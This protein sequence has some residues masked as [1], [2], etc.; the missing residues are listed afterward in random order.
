MAYLLTA[1]TAS[2]VTASL[3]LMLLSAPEADLLRRGYLSLI[4][5]GSSTPITG[6]RLSCSSITEETL[7]I[8]Y[9][10]GTESLSLSC[11][12]SRRPLP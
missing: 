10:M 11:V 1:L 6:A 7:H 5:R 3:T 12:D 2:L 8:T 9:D 4:L